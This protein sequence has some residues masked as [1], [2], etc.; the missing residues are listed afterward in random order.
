[1]C[2]VVDIIDHT[3]MSQFVLL[4]VLD[5][6]F[7]FLC[8]SDSDC[9]SP[10]RAVIGIIDYFDFVSLTANLKQ[11]SQTRPV[12]NCLFFR[13]TLSDHRS[14]SSSN[15]RVCGATMTQ[16][17]SGPDDREQIREIRRS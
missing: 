11:V 14:V 7:Y 10:S 3:I 4:L 2:S 8:F 15:L 16:T 12:K 13:C 1:M 17:I 9:L 6:S 5:R